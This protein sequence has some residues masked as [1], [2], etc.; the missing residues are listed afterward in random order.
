M[1]S[2]PRTTLTATARVLVT[3]QRRLAV[4][5]DQRRRSRKESHCSLH[6]ETFST[7]EAFMQLTTEKPRV[8]TEGIRPKLI[9]PA[10]TS[11]QNMEL[12]EIRS[13]YKP[14]AGPQ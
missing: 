13:S 8:S 11:I 1:D 7:S 12:P 9:R 6:P 10:M 5:A 3:E 2:P 4:P 14:T